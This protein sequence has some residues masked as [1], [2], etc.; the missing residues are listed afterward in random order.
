M[1]KAK[2]LIGLGAILLGVSFLGVNMAW[3]HPAPFSHPHPH[4]YRPFPNPATI[5]PPKP[6]P[7]PLWKW[8][9]KKDALAALDSNNY[10]TWSKVMA[11]SWIATKIN[12]SNFSTL[13]N[14]RQYAKQGDWVNANSM[15]RA[16]DLPNGPVWWLI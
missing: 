3:A 15:L 12:S 14:A 10:E 9:Q 7:A 1:K 8:V 6:A 2:F 11:G 13:Y 4:P 16:L 5:R